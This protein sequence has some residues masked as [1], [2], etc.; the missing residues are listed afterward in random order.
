[1]VYLI[2]ILN[3]SKINYNRRGKWWFLGGI[4]REYGYTCYLVLSD[5][6]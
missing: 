5:D 4:L 3:N 1:M 6:C 2:T